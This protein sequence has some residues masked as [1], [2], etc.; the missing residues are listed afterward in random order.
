[1]KG[2]YIIDLKKYASVS[3]IDFNKLKNKTILISGATGL[4]GRYFIDLIMYLNINNNLNCKVIGLSHNIEKAKQYLHYFGNKNFDYIAHDVCFPITYDGEID[5]VIHCASNTSPQQYVTKPIETI[6]TNVLGT[7]NLLDLSFEKNVKKFV[8]V[9]SFEV[10]GQV[11]ENKNIGENDYGYTDHLL[12]RS[13]YPESKKLSENLCIAYSNEKNVNTSIVRLSRIFGP[14][15]NP[16][17]SLSISQFINNGI[18]CEDIILKSDG[19]QNYSFNYVGDVVTAIIKILL[20]GNNCEAYNVA[21]EKFNSKLKDFASFITN[22]NKK[23]L[24]YV[25]PTTKESIGY[26][27]TTMTIL[28]DAKIKEIGW[29][30]LSN[31]KEKIFDTLDILSDET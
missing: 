31:L 29:Y 20:D 8:F 22:W 7:K 1:M 6:M 5:Y 4:V 28:D 21:N 16:D 11:S 30:P 15:M 24:K 18:N 12:L 26:S 3:F 10:Y 9:S 25:I 13:C 23:S 27:N 17:S 2:K 19:L 14:T